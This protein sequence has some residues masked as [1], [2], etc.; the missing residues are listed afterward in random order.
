MDVR[1]S[2]LAKAPEDKEKIDALYEKMQEICCGYSV[3]IIDAAMVRIRC[4]ISLL[5]EKVIFSSKD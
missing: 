1:K 3:D 2:L 4:K 5:K